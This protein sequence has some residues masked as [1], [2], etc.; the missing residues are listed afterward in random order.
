MNQAN[1][2]FVLWLVGLSG[3]GKSTLSKSIINQLNKQNIKVES[4]DGDAIRE[5][6]PQTGFSKKER[7]QHNKRVAY[8]AS[9]L[10]RNGISVIVS[11]IAPY[12]ES[13]DYANSVCKNYIEVFV[14]ASIDVCE[15]R[16]V[17]GLYKKV[18][19]GEIKHFTGIDDPFEPPINADVELNT[20][21]QTVEE[22]S[23]IILKYLKNYL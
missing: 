1:K 19:S 17:K 16:D 9:I 14:D 8:I 23:K 4:L 3:S 20:D 5:M 18:R 7:V 10:E 15:K 13:R 11:L 12:Q 6:L 2:P 21:Q 22:S